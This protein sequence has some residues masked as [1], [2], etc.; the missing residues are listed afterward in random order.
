MH[1]NEHRGTLIPKA[2]SFLFKRM[3]KSRPFV[4]PADLIN[5]RELL[6][7]DSGDVTDLLFSS[8][9]VNYFHRNHPRIAMTLIVHA[10]DAEIAKSV[11]K[12]KKMI[13]Y[14]RKQM[15]IYNADYMTLLKR[16]KKRDVDSAILLGKGFSL[17]RY[18]IAFAS[19]AS[20]RIGFENP[21]AFP[22]L[23]CEIRLTE[24]TYEGNR[25]SKVLNSV[26]LRPDA[27]LGSID[28]AQ[29]ELNHAKQ[30]IHFR[31]PEK[32]FLTVGIDPGRGKTKHHIIPEIIAYLANNLASRR[33]VKFLVLTHPWEDKIIESF[34]GSLKSEV[35]DL[36]PSKANETIALL[37]QC[38][39]FLSGNTNLFHFAAALNVPTIGLFTKYDDQKWVPD[40]APSVRIFKGMLG[41]KLSLKSFF[42]NVEEVLDADVKV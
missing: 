32:D 20:I 38:D 22:F 28:L 37:S 24:V 6:L 1:E 5:S 36:R 29:R 7:I 2:F 26:G 34:I 21:L 33:K 15:H 25:M 40:G 10:P 3:G 16:L 8:Q 41:E 27:S 13:T 17:E 30:L 12:I 31:K 9:L 18:L 11:M 23:N 35:I 19:G 39:L 14:E 4:L 42:F